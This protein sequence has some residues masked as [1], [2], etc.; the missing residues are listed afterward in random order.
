MVPGGPPHARARDL[1]GQEARAP[2]ARGS[3]VSAI[4]SVTPAMTPPVMMAAA[5]DALMA[6]PKPAALAP[7]APGGDALAPG[8]PGKRR[9]IER[10]IP[11][12]SHGDAPSRPMIRPRLSAPDCVSARPLLATSGAL[13]HTGQRLAEGKPLRILAIGSSTT[14]GVGATAPDR[15]YPVQLEKEIERLL[16]HARVDLRVS[17]VG[18]ETAVQTL[19]RLERE[20]AAHNPDLV[21]WQVGT[22][23][24]LSDVGEET[25]KTLLEKGIA[26]VDATQADLILMNQQFFPS[27]RHK[28]RYERFVRMVQDAGLKKRACVFNRYALMQQWGEDS[29]DTLRAMLASDEFHM[30]DRGYACM[31]RV[32]ADEIV[33]AAWQDHVDTS[34]M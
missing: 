7:S 18:G 24:A 8:E 3:V 1:P 34:A 26:S 27:I 11:E 25:F 15:T 33:R 31:A 20:L 21:I 10:K 30:S 14:E 17:G 2:E 5:G 22:N 13:R 32:L 19:A 16:P 28:A 9:V 6:P 4:A 12:M 29:A 23:D